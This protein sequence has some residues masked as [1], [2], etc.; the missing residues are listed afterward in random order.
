[1][2]AN[3]TLSAF[4]EVNIEGS[5]SKDELRKELSAKGVTLTREQFDVLYAAIDEDE[6]GSINVEKYTSFVE[7]MQTL[8]TRAQE[9]RPSILKTR[10]AT[11]E[12]TTSPRSPGRPVILKT[13][14]ATIESTTSPRSHRLNS[15]RFSRHLASTN[16]LRNLVGSDINEEEGLDTGMSRTLTVNYPDEEEKAT[17]SMPKLKSG[18][19]S[20]H[21]A[22]TND[23]RNLVGSN[24]NE[25][26]R[27]GTKMSRTLTVNY[28]DEEEKKDEEIP[29]R[30]SKLRFFD[31]EVREYSLTASHNPSVSSGVAIGLDWT[32]SVNYR[33]HIDTFEDRRSS[34]RAR[35]F[36]KERKL[37][38]LERAKILREHG[39]TNKEIQVATKHAN[40]G[41]NKRKK[42]VGEMRL[43]KKHEKMEVK[44]D[45][46]KKFVRMGSKNEVLT[47]AA[48]QSQNDIFAERLNPVLLAMMGNVTLS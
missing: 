38:R 44:I 34:K 18:R 40:I 15:G 35:D 12:S 8:V 42:S 46:L 30:S 26:K 29:R 41:R 31:V 9:R 23:L 36:I 4:K 47:K 48:E 33:L 32:Y 21:L 17:G 1:M 20:R 7:K 19:F 6:S 11:I 13:H 24:V 25:E 37:T 5:I 16:D 45:K 14:R 10:R 3:T 43:D 39:V 27:L 28:P 22:S 2:A